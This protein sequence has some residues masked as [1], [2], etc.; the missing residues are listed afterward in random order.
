MTVSIQTSLEFG[1]AK[2][3]HTQ[4]AYTLRQFINFRYDISVVAFLML[5]V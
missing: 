1:L 5:N 2:L 3:T 4:S